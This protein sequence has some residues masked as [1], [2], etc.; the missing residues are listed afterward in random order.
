MAGSILL[1]MMTLLHKR[2]VF[3]VTFVYAF[4]NVVEHE[5]LCNVDFGLLFLRPHFLV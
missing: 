2:S 1:T 4:N 3:I 5:C